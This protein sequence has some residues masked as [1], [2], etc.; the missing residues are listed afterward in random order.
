MSGWAIIAAGKGHGPIRSLKRASELPEPPPPPPPP[1]EW[2]PPSSSEWTA[3]QTALTDAGASGIVLVAEATGL[4]EDQDGEEGVSINDLVGGVPNW[5]VPEPITGGGV[6]SG[7]QRPAYASSGSLNAL[8]FSGDTSISDNTR[9]NLPHITGSEGYICIAA[10]LN[11]NTN[12]GAGDAFGDML[13][14]ILPFRILARRNG[15]NPVPGVRVASNVHYDFTGGSFASAWAMLEV[16]WQG[17]TLRI[18]RNGEQ[19]QTFTGVTWAANPAS[20]IARNTY[21][22][23]NGEAGRV[24]VW[25]AAILDKAM[26]ETEY[27]A[28]RAFVLAGTS[29]ID[30]TPVDPPPP[31]TGDEPGA[32]GAA[33]A[34]VTTYSGLA[35]ACA[36]AGPGTIIQL[37][38]GNYSGTKI[39]V[40]ASGTASNPIV[41]R[42]ANLLGANVP[43]GFNLSGTNIIIRGL[44]F[45]TSGGAASNQIEL[46]NNNQV[47]RCRFKSA[48]GVNIHP[49]VGSGGK[50]MYCEFSSFNAGDSSQAS[51]FCI[52]ANYKSDMDYRNLEVGYC[53]WYNLPNK[54]P[55]YQDRA[56]ASIAT[57]HNQTYSRRST[58]WHIHHCLLDATGDCELTIKTMDNII[59]HC[60]I[61][62]SNC[63]FNQRFGGRNTWRNCWTEN[64]DPF[65]IFGDDNKI[66]SCT[67]V[68]SGKF[69]V[70]AGNQ[71]PTNTTDGGYPRAD[72]TKMT[73]CVGAVEVGRRW[74]SV[75]PAMNLPARDTRIEAHTGTV[76][77][78]G[79]Y[80]TGT[81]QVGTTSEPTSSRFKMTASQV[82]PSGTG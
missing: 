61:S 21:E 52:R 64:A 25:R 82:G 65:I 23:W 30:E 62:N 70:F 9:L 55:T 4:R 8:L 47:W 63:E 7:S 16:E 5:L 46:W 18:R 48:G 20:M 74:S 11:A 41:I 27:E 76:T 57:T 60:T 31:E 51:T 19:W 69:E 73:G 22:P 75:S 35:S 14:Q 6:A 81:V 72:R 34:S 38:N 37:A 24:S 17:S 66:I 42:A 12:R 56:R 78:N 67:M 36:A 28:V 53:Y 26:T 10:R 54:T 39:T 40:S 79:V 2:A 43:N 59:E 71:E 15:A 32:A 29:I 58:Q 68:N 80:Q 49:F 44:D 45:T 50:I 1:S 3:M 33:T 13:L 77:L